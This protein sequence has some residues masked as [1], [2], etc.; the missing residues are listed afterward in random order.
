MKKNWKAVLI[1]TV[2]IAGTLGGTALAKETSVQQGELPAAVKDAIAAKYPTAKLQKSAK[3]VER[4]KTEYEFL[5]DVN[6]RQ[7]EVALAPDGT[8]LSEEQRL[9]P[10]ELPGPVKT[11]LASSPFANARVI[12]AERELKG[13]KT[14]YE[15]VVEQKGESSELV[16]DDSG[17]LTKSGEA[18]EADEG[19]DQ[20]GDND[21][22][23]SDG[24]GESDDD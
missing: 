1:G 5:L 11:G 14:T 13:G 3:D 15:L 9:D 17:R 18:D 4:G 2:A 12:R 7:T 23:Q 16:F 10:A 8:L 6:G 22:H 24:D 20:R 21:H 19:N